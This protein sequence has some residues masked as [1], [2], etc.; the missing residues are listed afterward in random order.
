[1]KNILIVFAAATLLTSCEKPVPRDGSEKSTASEKLEVTGMKV[2]KEA[3]ELRD[4]AGEKA[5]VAGE[6]LS[7]SAEKAGEK[8]S[9]AAAAAKVSAGNLLE[10]AGARMEKAGEAMQGDATPTPNR[11]Y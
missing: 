5:K 4:T 7:E 11:N 8:L 9:E 2:K 1:M 3:V 6:A 10:K